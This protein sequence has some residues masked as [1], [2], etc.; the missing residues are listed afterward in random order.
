MSGVRNRKQGATGKAADPVAA[1]SFALCTELNSSPDIAL[2]YVRYWG[3][4]SSAV[5]ARVAA[6][7]SAGFDVQYFIAG[8]DERDIRIQLKTKAGSV[9]E[10]KEVLASMAAEAK[11]QLN[12]DIDRTY[13]S[14]GSKSP[15]D[16]HFPKPWIIGATLGAWFAV[17]MLTYADPSVLPADVIRFRE[18][19]S[20][21]LLERVLTGWSILHGIEAAVSIVLCAYARMPLWTW[22][23]WPMMISVF[24]TPSLQNCLKVAI[25]HAMYR[26]PETF[27]IPKGVLEGEYRSTPSGKPKSSEAVPLLS[28][29]D[30]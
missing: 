14:P 4:M 9:E 2:A 11:K 25:R 18:L 26:D 27:G 28:G 24:G 13:R 6:V 10:A 17:L 16:V 8:D 29:K 15:P 12:L 20:K 21:E 23:A 1:Q 22:L 19:A 5:R 7:D 3:S 30:E